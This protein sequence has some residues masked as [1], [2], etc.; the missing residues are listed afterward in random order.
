MPGDYELAEQAFLEWCRE[1]GA[2]AA[3][4]RRRLVAAAL[5]IGR[6]RGLARLF[7]VLPRWQQRPIRVRTE[8]ARTRKTGAPLKQDFPCPHGIPHRKHPHA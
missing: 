2:P 7:K 6:G 8:S 1:L 4:F 3:A 5:D